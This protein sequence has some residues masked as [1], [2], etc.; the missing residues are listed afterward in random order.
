MSGFTGSPVALLQV[1]FRAVHFS[2][3]LRV[4]KG[5]PIGKALEANSDPHS[6]FL[7]AI[8]AGVNCLMRRHLRRP[9]SPPADNL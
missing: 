7:K 1:L 5:D 2:G 9:G 8:L 3:L 6:P 4:N